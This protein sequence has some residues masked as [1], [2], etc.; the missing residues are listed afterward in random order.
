MIVPRRLLG[1]FLVFSIIIAVVVL[2]NCSLALTTPNYPSKYPF[3]VSSDVSTSFYHLPIRQGD[4]KIIDGEIMQKYAS[5]VYCY[6]ISPSDYYLC[7][8]TGANWEVIRCLNGVNVRLWLT[9][10]EDK[11]YYVSRA[12]TKGLDDMRVFQYN[13]IYIYDKIVR[14]GTE[15]KGSFAA[16]GDLLQKG[17]IS[18]NNGYIQIFSDGEGSYR[19]E[20]WVFLPQYKGLGVLL[21]DCTA[22]GVG[23]SASFPSEIEYTLPHISPAM[24]S[25][26]REQHPRIQTRHAAIRIE[27]CEWMGDDPVLFIESSH[28]IR[29]MPWNHEEIYPPAIDTVLRSIKATVP[30]VEEPP[31]KEIVLGTPNMQIIRTLGSMKIAVPATLG[32]ILLIWT[33][34]SYFRRSKKYNV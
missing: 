2:P 32:L 20:D 19:F 3:C 4:G 7:I 25:V 12:C 31:K 30:R 6:Y 33:L 10:N 14:L 27:E 26:T 29:L 22:E 21:Q 23:E 13:P 1:F 34:R 28:N 18:S 8:A 16:L 24:I 17:R 5:K 9:H 15:G 11:G